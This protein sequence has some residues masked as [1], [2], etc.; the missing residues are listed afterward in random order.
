MLS[1][2]R[3]S[4]YQGERFTA[5]PAHS[6]LQDDSCCLLTL[7]LKREELLLLHTALCEQ[8]A[9]LGNTISELASFDLPTDDAQALANRLAGLSRRMCEALD[10]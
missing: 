4:E 7:T 2:I 8:R 10:R 1:H 5:L 3:Q 6:T 9:K